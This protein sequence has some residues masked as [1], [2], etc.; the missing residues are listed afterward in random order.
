MMS[1]SKFASSVILCFLVAFAGSSVTMPSVL[2]WYVQLNKPFFSPPN[3]IF[4]PVWTIL[5]LLMGI[6]LYLVWN[7][8]LKNKI[9]EF[10]GIAIRVFIYQ[11]ILNFLWSL[12]FF[13]LHNPFLALITIF[14]LWLS[15]F[16]LIKYSYKVSKMSAYLLIPYIVWVSFAS[17]L[18]L[19][20]VILN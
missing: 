10:Q 7:K 8:S 15:I 19:F 3:W 6:S 16:T 1:T 2:T 13:G 11:L 17:I 20:I 5:Y 14:A 9:K 4:G 18:N 12:V